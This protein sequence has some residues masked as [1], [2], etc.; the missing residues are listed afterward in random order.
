[1]QEAVVNALTHRGYGIAGS[2]VIV[3]LLLDRI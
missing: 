2:R 3:T 1:L